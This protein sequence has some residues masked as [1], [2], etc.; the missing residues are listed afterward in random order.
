MKVLIT[1]GAG[2]VGTELTKT[3]VKCPDIDDILI[4]D[5][6]GRQ[7]YNLFLGRRLERHEKVNGYDE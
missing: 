7:N 2:Y 3:L 4:Y 6:L 1:G 5:N